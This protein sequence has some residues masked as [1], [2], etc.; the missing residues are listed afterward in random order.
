MRR[1]VS[2]SILLASISAGL[3]TAALAESNSLY[4]ISNGGLVLV[5]AFPDQSACVTAGR[6]ATTASSPSPGP[7][8][9]TLVCVP[10]APSKKESE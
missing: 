7:I 4:L 8:T 6:A 2:T 5:G 1:I 3:P 9:V 10:T